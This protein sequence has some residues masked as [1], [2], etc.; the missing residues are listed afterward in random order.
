M[1]NRLGDFVFGGSNAGKPKINPNL[2]HDTVYNEVDALRQ[3]LAKRKHA[4]DMDKSV[5]KAK[6]E[7]VS[8]LQTHDRKPLNCWQEVEAFKA[9]V[10]RLERAFVEKNG[11]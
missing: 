1:L 6:D 7:V 11:A 4:I 3:R 8:C 5:A 9:E 10:G 2:D